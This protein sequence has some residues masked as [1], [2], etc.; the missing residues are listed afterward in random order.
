MQS[1][2]PLGPRERAADKTPVSCFL[3]AIQRGIDWKRQAT[4]AGAEPTERTDT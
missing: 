4:H 3:A 2:A 1:A